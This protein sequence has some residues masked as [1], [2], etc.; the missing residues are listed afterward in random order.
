MFY[1]IKLENRRDILKDI[2]LIGIDLSLYINIK[3]QINMIS[4]LNLNTKKYEFSI[5]IQSFKKNKH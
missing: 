4:V 1:W 5:F 3:S 2:Y